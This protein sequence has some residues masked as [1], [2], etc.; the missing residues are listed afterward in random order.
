MEGAGVGKMGYDPD[1]NIFMMCEKPDRAAFS[2]MPEG[3]HVRHVWES[4]I[5]FWKLMPLDGWDDADRQG[6]LRYME[7]CFERMYAPKGD[8]FYRT[9]L[10]VA[11]E[12]DHPVGTCFT[13]KMYDRFTTMHWLK[14]LGK[15]EGRGIGRALL[16]TVMG[17]LAEDD[18]PVYLHTQTGSFRAIHLYG[19]FGFKILRDPVVGN[20][21]N[22]IDRGL[23]ILEKLMPDGHYRKLQF[24]NAPQDFL[25]AVADHGTD[26]F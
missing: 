25:E 3:Y 21:G 26:D 9:C 24:C 18:Y 6:F 12:S 16:S 11:D 10:V 14:V 22:D 13:W 20:R 2:P 17:K 15:H 7:D 4:E 23:P 5:G 19:E 8:L 1:L